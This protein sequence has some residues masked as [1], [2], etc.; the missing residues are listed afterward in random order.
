MN[1]ELQ[2]T[3]F[4]CDADGRVR[5]KY[6]VGTTNVKRLDLILSSLKKQLGDIVDIESV[7]PDYPFYLRRLFL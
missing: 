7:H 5:P 2:G 6:T 3:S 4:V 1:D